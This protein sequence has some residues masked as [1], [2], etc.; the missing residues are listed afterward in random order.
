MTKI[1]DSVLVMIGESNI[2][3]E[4]EKF[5]D[6]AN[7]VISAHL[8]IPDGAFYKWAKEP[9]S[10]L[11]PLY[12]S[13]SYNGGDLVGVSM[14]GHVES[15]GNGVAPIVGVF[16]NQKYRKTGLALRL[17]TSSLERYKKMN[18]HQKVML[19]DGS[20]IKSG[21]DLHDVLLNSGFEVFDYNR[22]LT[23]KIK[24]S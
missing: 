23:G 12:V 22:V 18:P 9:D 2:T 7:S 14:V 20:R 1:T 10:N 8:Y 21:T 15:E 13:T 6:V 19:Y 16:V 5:S 17:L 3:F 24:W 4:T 11:S